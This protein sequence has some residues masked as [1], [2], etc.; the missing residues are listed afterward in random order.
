MFPFFICL[1]NISLARPWN[2]WKSCLK[3]LSDTDR[4]PRI[5]IG[6]QISLE[7]WTRCWVWH[8]CWWRC[9]CWWCWCLLRGPCC[10][11]IPCEATSFPTSHSLLCH[12]LQTPGDILKTLGLR[13]RDPVS[14]PVLKAFVDLLN[15]LHLV[16]NQDQVVSP[17]KLC[18]VFFYLIST[19]T[20]KKRMN[21]F[22]DKP[23]DDIVTSFCSW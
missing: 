13:C 9:W 10:A 15:F 8:Y 14:H 7:R 11:Y 20:W 1:R 12:R 5:W 6:L 4:P 3:V 21:K 17:G 23:A 2:T 19:Y 18:T 16:R 22:V